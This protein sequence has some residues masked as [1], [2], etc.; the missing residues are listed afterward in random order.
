[1]ASVLTLYCSDATASN[2]S[3]GSLVTVQPGTSTTATGWTVASVAANQFSLQTYAFEKAAASFGGAAK[4]DAAPATNAVDCWRL[5]NA[6]TGVFSA[7]TWYSSLS[8]IAVT[9]GGIQDG[10]ARFRIWRSGN[11]AGTGATEIT[12][13]TM[14]GSL[15]TNL[16]TSAAQSS[17]AS[18]Q[19]SVVTL[20][21]EYLFM[22]V[23]W[24]TL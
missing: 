11:A 12:A 19:I 16:T 20:T 14:V 15:V 24:E 3:A 5:S 2:S 21:N 23:A 7:G 4:P 10:R 18:T 8:V 9:A 6:T 17:S 1:M 22:Q 13:G